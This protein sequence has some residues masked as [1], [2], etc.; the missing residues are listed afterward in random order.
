[1]RYFSTKNIWSKEKYDYIRLNYGDDDDYDNRVFSIM[2]IPEGEKQA[3]KF[4]FREECD[5]FFKA[6]LT[7]QQTIEMLQ[8][9][10]EWIKSK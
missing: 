10:I 2:K 8:E 7:K 1:M 4:R 9:A 6:H 5:Q 3:G